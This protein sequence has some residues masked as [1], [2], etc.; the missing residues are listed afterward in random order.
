MALIKA[1]PTSP[2]RRFQVK[3]SRSH[4]HKGGPEQSLVVHKNSTGARNHFGRQTVR[5]QGDGHKQ[6]YRLVDF[7]RNKDGVPARSS[8]SNTTRTGPRTS[9]SC[10]TPTASA[11]TSSRRRASRRAT[12]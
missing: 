5:H 4:L 2:G 1:K 12:R 10:C 11:A 7:L 3:I 9:R 6:K 8:V